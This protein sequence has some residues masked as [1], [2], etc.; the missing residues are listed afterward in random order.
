MKDLFVDVVKVNTPN[1]LTV[2]V[3]HLADV[4]EAVTILLGLISIV[5]T[6]IIIR[7]N[8]RQ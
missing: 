8:L 4:R 6:I 5:S 7:K 2:A 3:V 1:V